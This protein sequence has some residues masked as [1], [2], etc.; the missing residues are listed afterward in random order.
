MQ[1]LGG[2]FYHKSCLMTPFILTRS[3]LSHSL[4][5]VPVTM[6]VSS[7][8]IQIL[9]QSQSANQVELIQL[10]PLLIIITGV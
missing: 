8:T 7:L 3:Q 4:F 10:H 5:Q 9:Q 6:E 2:N 1:I